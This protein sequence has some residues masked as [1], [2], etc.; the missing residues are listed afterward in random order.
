MK[1]NYKISGTP[2][3]PVLV[4]S[5]SLGAD[6][7]MWDE[8]IP[9]L[10]PYF[11]VLQYDSRGHGGSEITT[12]PYTIALLG[13]D[14][15][16]L[17]DE[18]KIEKAYFCGLSMG[19]L[20]GQWLGIHHPDRFSKII[21]ANT[22]A[23]IGDAEAWNS[24]IEIINKSGLEAIVAATMERWF[25]KGF[26]AKNPKRVSE[27]KAMFLNTDVLGY[28]NC[29]AAVRDADFRADLHKITSKILVITGDEDT[30]TN[31]EHAEFLVKQI[32]D[33]T[34]SILPARH[35]SATELPEQFALLLIQFI[36]GETTFDKGMH[37]RRTVLGD[38]H[39]DRATNN[40]NEF[41]GEF[42]NFIS[43]Y[44]WGEIW[45]RPGLSKHNR[46][47]ITIA[48]LIALNRKAE[49]Q[50]HIRAAFNNGVTKNEIKEVI[51]QSGLYCGLPAAN[52]AIHTAE[53]VFKD[54]KIS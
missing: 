21:I 8:L 1:T 18:L 38:A 16:D 3:S 45:T 37:V 10:L 47:L 19:G 6:N 31:I 39:V 17:L 51:M 12:E 29:C 52:D 48:M 33:A 44:A 23:K 15:I 7:S 36:V 5:N 42:Q 20:I 30:V 34:L 25:T 4:F 35:L 28:A 13:Q 40:I 43:N 50:M 22:A 49:L 54:L 41:N 32:P 24:R 26:H 53:E 14:V 9:F 46:S 27:T 2:N 11:Q